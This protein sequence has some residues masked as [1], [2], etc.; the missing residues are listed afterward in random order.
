MC[1]EDT[2]KSALKTKQGLYKWFVMPFGLYNSQGAFMRL[3]NVVL[4]PFLDTFAV[5]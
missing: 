5:V 4:R 1:E 2:W 3:M